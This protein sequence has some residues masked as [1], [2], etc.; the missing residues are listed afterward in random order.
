ML[1]TIRR[2]KKQTLREVAKFGSGLVFADFLC[3]LWV[4]LGGHL[5]MRFFGIAFN[6]A[7]TMAWM[8][9]DI[10]LFVFLVHFGW[11]MAERPRTSTEKK[12]HMA[13]G[14]VFALVALLHLSRILFGWDFEIGSWHV[15]YWVN[16]LGTVV[17]AF[18]AYISFHL[19]SAK[20]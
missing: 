11:H 3:G 2:M 20:G 6:E 5:P 4:S 10:V 18:L 9:F 16:G 8:V 15:P 14:I 7:G 17:T 19:S 13:A 1:N 12:F